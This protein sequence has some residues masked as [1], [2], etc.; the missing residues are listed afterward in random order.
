MPMSD[1]CVPMQ[2][3][4]PEGLLNAL[5]QDKPIVFFINPPYGTAS[6]DYGKGAKNTKGAGA[7]DSAIY[8]EMV[9]NKM[10]NASKN[11]YAQFLYRIMRIK[12]GYHLTNCHIGLF[13]PTL[14]LTGPSW[15]VFRKFFLL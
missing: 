11:L 12:Q 8:A 2:K 4:P 13:S 7:C 5:R 15:A 3:E 1:D 10:G 6:S 14:F 9:K